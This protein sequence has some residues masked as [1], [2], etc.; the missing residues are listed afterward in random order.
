MATFRQNE[1][2]IMKEVFIVAGIPTILLC[3][4]VQKEYILSS[5]YWMGFILTVLLVLGVYLLFRKRYSRAIS[6][7]GCI[8]TL[9]FLSFLI[10]FA[11]Y[12]SQLP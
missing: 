10:C 9:I 11:I 7:I 2:V 5:F 1:P 4:L 12:K 3:F 8:S 6:A